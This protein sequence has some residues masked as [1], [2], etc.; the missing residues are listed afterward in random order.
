MTILRTN[1]YWHAQK[2]TTYFVRG[3]FVFANI[4]PDCF[5]P[6][7]AYFVPFICWYFVLYLTLHQNT[8]DYETAKY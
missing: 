8:N 2:T 3:F 1:D 6:Q 7:I 5:I 4:K